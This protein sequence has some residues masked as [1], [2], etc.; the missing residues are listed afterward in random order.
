M[1]HHKQGTKMTPQF[2]EHGLTEDQAPEWW[3]VSEKYGI[4]SWPPEAVNQSRLVRMLKMAVKAGDEKVVARINKVLE[5]RA[6]K[7]LTA[8]LSRKLGPDMLA[9]LSGIAGLCETDDVMRDSLEEAGLLATINNVIEKC[10]YP[11]RAERG[12]KRKATAIA[13]A[14]EERAAIDATRPKGLANAKED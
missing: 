12:A 10:V 7:G 6:S 4:V 3:T 5:T 11:S 1:E 9:I 14:A 2:S 8:S 13:E